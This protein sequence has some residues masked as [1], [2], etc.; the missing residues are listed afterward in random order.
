MVKGHEAAL[1]FRS[2]FHLN[3]AALEPL[4]PD[5]HPDRSSEQIGIVEFEPGSLIPVIQKDIDL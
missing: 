5:S 1:G 4:G 3:L 2:Q